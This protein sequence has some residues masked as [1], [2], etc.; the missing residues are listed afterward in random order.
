MG[1]FEKCWLVYAYKIPYRMVDCWTDS[2][3]V[4][5]GSYTLSASTG[6]KAILMV[7]SSLWTAIEIRQSLNHHNWLTGHNLWFSVT[8]F[9]FL[10]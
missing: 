8:N 2:G 6:I 5:I 7:I 4:D 9:F 1:W 3:N 10:P